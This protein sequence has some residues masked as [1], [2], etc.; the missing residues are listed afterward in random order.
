MEQFEKLFLP[1]AGDVDDIAIFEID[2]APV[3]ADE[4]SNIAKIDEVAIVDAKKTVGQEDVLEVFEEAGNEQ[5]GAVGEEEFGIIG[6]GFD[7]DDIADRD[8]F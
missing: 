5:G 4:F 3:T 1:A 7:A 2:L 8:E 6:A